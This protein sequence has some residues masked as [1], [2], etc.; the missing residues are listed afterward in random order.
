[1]KTRN[2]RAAL[3]PKA[4]HT[5]DT[6]GSRHSQS[7]GTAFVLLCLV[8]LAPM[9]INGCA[10]GGSAGTGAP[11]TGP[12]ISVNPGAVAFSNVTVGTSASQTIT[13]SNPGSASLTVS[14]IAPT[15]PGYSI[16]GV[17][18]PLTIPSNG[19]ASFSVR[20]T[21]P[22]AGTDPGTISVTSNAPSSPNSIPVSGTATA[23]TAPAISV[24]PGSLAFGSV[25]VG[26][27]GTQ[28]VTIQ[29]TGAAN[30]TISSAAASGAGYTVSGGT[31]APVA[32]GSSASLTVT[33]APSAAGSVQ[34]SL[35][36]GSNAS[37]S[38][39]PVSLSGSGVGAVPGLSV[40]SSVVA[41]GNVTVGNAGTQTVTL[42]NS[43]NANL[44][45]SQATVSGVGFSAVGLQTP[46]TLAEGQ[47]TT[48]TLG[49][50]PTAVVTGA[51]GAVSVTSNASNSPTMITMSGSGV[52]SASHSVALS[53][54]ASTSSSVVSYN[55]YRG[56]ES[57]GPYTLEGNSPNPATS[58]VDTTVEAGQTYY[59]VVTAVDASGDESAYSNVTSA[60]VPTS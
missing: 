39:T 2:L 33:F 38:P 4:V 15:T 35:S 28:S 25:T 52:Q 42:T 45:I 19:T 49:F 48:V 10:V 34:G 21:P 14:S 30:L 32:P 37:N 60:T 55:I 50:T 47:R 43:G 18:T 9:L 44:T 22:A 1:M 24:I 12:S 17:S 40:S 5:G 57:G 29:N 6:I 11:T 20:F 16:S 36:I 27:S 26:T 13:I 46:A 41:F 54:T 56:T 51:S 7:M 58:Y 23:A 59:Y 53:W 8:V 31:L 3:R